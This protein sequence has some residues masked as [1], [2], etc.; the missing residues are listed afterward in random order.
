MQKGISLSECLICLVIVALLATIGL[1]SYRH[2]QLKAHRMNAQT[3]LH[4]YALGQGEYRLDNV[5][6]AN[7]EQLG[8]QPTDRY[9]FD[10]MSVTGATFTLRAKAINQQKADVGCEILLIDQSMLGQPK[11]CWQ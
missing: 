2:Q 5:S 3:R 11:D 8:M 1:P 6:Y 7:S 10:V 4:G 9:Q